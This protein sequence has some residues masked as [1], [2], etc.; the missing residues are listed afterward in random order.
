MPQPPTFKGMPIDLNKRYWIRHGLSGNYF[1][2]TEQ[3]TWT[4]KPRTESFLGSELPDILAKYSERLAH[5]IFITEV[6]NSPE[7]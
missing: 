2:A 7:T 3:G 1:H 4:N 6:L 5:N